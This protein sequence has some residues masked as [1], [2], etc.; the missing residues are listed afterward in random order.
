MLRSESLSLTRSPS[1]RWGDFEEQVKIYEKPLYH[2]AYRLTGDIN[3]AQDLLQEGFLKAYRSYHRFQPG[4]AFDRWMFQIIYRLFVDNYRKKRRRPFISSLDE[5]HPHL[6]QAK[7]TDVPDYSNIPEDSALRQELGRT[8]QEAL[9]LIPE[10]FRVAVILCDIQG[11]S[12]EEI[13]Q[14]LGCSLGTVRS[15]IHRGRRL[16]RELLK[17][18]FREERRRKK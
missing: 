2:F 9:M 1:D 3:D 6:E 11:L 18:Y 14:V 8:I 16:L 10:N 4:T 12:Y 7:T 17:P 13:S 15:R 5:P